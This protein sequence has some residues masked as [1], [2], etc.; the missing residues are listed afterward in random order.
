MELS[1]EDS[2]MRDINFRL[3][4]PTVTLAFPVALLKYNRP[5]TTTREAQA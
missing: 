4:P 2:A 3:Q 5:I 1:R